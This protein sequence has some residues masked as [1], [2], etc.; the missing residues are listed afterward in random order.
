MANPEARLGPLSK[1][2]TCYALTH[3]RN[4]PCKGEHQC[5]LEI[6]K[7]TKKAA[8]VGHIHYDKNNNPIN[9]G[10]HGYP[11]FD[12]KGNVIQ[13]IE[14]SLDITGR[15]KAEEELRFF[16]KA[17]DGASDAIGMS[18]PEGKHYY[19]NEAFNKLFKLSVNEVKG[20]QGL[21]STVYADEKVGREVFK[22]IMAGNPWVGE[23]KML[24]RM[25][26]KMDIFLRAYAIKDEKGKVIGLIGVHTDITEKKKAEDEL[27]NRLEELERFHKINSW[28]GT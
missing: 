21:P 17:V 3:K 15:K 14:Y 2:S 20:K 5:P 10:V 16:K 19:Q 18:T 9:M 24:D 28:Q 8:V 12:S 11:I 4:E 26:N 1:N 7:K 6:V 25:G 13:M 23:V 22:T 27:K